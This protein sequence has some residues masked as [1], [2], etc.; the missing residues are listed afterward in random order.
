MYIKVNG[1]LL[2]LAGDPFILVGL[3]RG[4]LLASALRVNKLLG[5]VPSLVKAF[6]FE[7]S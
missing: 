1:N 7:V 2:I 5:Y 6:L 4:R 3:Q